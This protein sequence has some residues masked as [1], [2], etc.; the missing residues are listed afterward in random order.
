M[1]YHASILLET[2]NYLMQIPYKIQDLT[3]LIKDNSK[4]I[5]N[6]TQHTPGTGLCSAQC[7]CSTEL[8]VSSNKLNEYSM[9]T[10]I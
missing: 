8:S 7:W 6:Y 2:V 3:L 1:S 9:R 10:E 5:C 4:N